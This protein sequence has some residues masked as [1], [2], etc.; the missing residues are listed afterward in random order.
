M[1]PPKVPGCK[2]AP[3]CANTD[4]LKSVTT[5]NAIF[6]NFL[7]NWKS[8]DSN[9]SQMSL[10]LCSLNSLSRVFSRQSSCNFPCLFAYICKGR[11]RSVL[12]SGDEEKGSRPL[13]LPVPSVD[14]TQRVLP[15]VTQ[16]F[17]RATFCHKLFQ[18]SNARIS[19]LKIYELSSDCESLQK[20]WNL[21]WFM[22]SSRTRGL[23]SLGGGGQLPSWQ[24]CQGYNWTIS[25][26]WHTIWEWC[27][28]G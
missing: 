16:S 13:D 11:G 20:E 7:C 12:I 21:V 5:T 15:T 4:S 23:R 22:A 25:T 3:L 18:G 24:S 19:L 17:T 9:E 1:I 2:W 26:R 28:G 6:A 27:F 8:V 14:G 10:P